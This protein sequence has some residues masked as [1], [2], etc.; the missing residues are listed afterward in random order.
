MSQIYLHI[1]ERPQD[2]PTDDEKIFYVRSYLRGTAQQWFQPNIFADGQAPI[3]LWDGN[4]TLFVQELA[5]NFGPHDPFGDTRIALETLTMKPG[6]RL[7]TYQLEFNT[8][9]VMTGYNEAALYRAYYR[10]LPSR[11]KDIL[12]QSPTP[13]SLAGLKAL[14]SQLDQRYHR[15]MGEKAAER[16]AANPPPGGKSSGDLAGSSSA[17]GG[18]GGGGG[19]S[20]GKGKGRGQSNPLPKS[21]AL[22]NSSPAGNAAQASG[23]KTAKPYASK[24]DSSGKLKA[25]ERDRRIKNNLCMFCGGAGHKTVDCKKRPGNAQGKAVA[26][27]PATAP[28]AHAS[29]SKS[30]N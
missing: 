6:D 5:T 9:A 16:A 2:F 24:L 29:T 22:T 12:A 19:K 17:G 27:T 13:T 18:S 23:S 10:G 3:P 21:N 8:H 30:K 1:A 26:A 7:A 20:K 25:E 4:W 15:R 14:A 28:A 11:L